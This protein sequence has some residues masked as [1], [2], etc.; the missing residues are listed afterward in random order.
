MHANSKRNLWEEALV[1]HNHCNMELILKVWTC[2]INSLMQ[3][4]TLLLRCLR[5]RGIHS[6]TQGSD[7]LDKD[8]VCGS[9][10]LC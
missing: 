1:D 8:L 6:L 5:V 9:W 3:V 4:L 2:S 7:L 10:L